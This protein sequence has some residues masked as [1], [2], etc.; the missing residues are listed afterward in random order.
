MINLKIKGQ[1]MS[2]DPFTTVFNTWINHIVQKFYLTQI[3]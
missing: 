2:G 3:L 1:R